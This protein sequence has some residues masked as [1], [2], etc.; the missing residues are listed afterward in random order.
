MKK[1]FERFAQYGIF[2][3]INLTIVGLLAVM[4]ILLVLLLNRFLLLPSLE[5]DK[6]LNE[7][8]AHSLYDVVLS[9]YNTIYNQT[10]LIT[11]TSHV[12][13]TLASAA[14]YPEKALQFDTISQINNYLQ[15]LLY[16]DSD[17]LDTLVLAVETETVY[18][19]SAKKTRVLSTRYD[20]YIR[21][22]EMTHL[23]ESDRNIC[24]FPAS[25]P[26]YATP[27]DT[28]VIT[29]A[30][31][32]YNPMHLPNK[33]LVGV[34]LVS[35]PISVFSNAYQYLGALSDGRVYVLNDADT[36]I[37]SNRSDAIGQPFSQH[38]SSH[39]QTTTYPV[40]ISGIRVLNS[41]SDNTVMKATTNMVR[42][43]LTVVIPSMLAMLLIV[44]LL[45]RQY[46]K[47]IGQLASAMLKIS[48]GGLNTRLPVSQKD[49]IG[50]LSQAF[51][52]MCEK[53]DANIRLAFHAELRR[54]TAEL[55]ALQ[56]QINPHFLYNTIESIRMRAMQDGNLDV[57]DMLMQLGQMFHWMISM[58]Q[59]IVYLEDEIDYNEAYL[60][61]Q[62]LRYEDSFEYQFDIPGDV[63]YFGI[64]KFTLQ[65]IIENAILHGLKENRLSGRITVT[66]LLEGDDLILQVQDN[67]SGIEPERLKRLQRHI[68]GE[69]SDPEF[70]VGMQNVHARIHLLFGGH[71][72]VSIHSHQD[73]GTTVTITLPALAKKEMEQ[74]ISASIHEEHDQEKV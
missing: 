29:F 21:L 19:F 35:Y 36:I 14:V 59:R 4:T 73:A 3:K 47:R 56:A 30:A 1:R 10:N 33:Q 61:L 67:G 39:D 40:G 72:G 51:N 68:S 60:D 32:I 62:K 64:P 26:S 15:T 28:Q 48:L 20:D 71:C 52:R 70:G 17:I 43:M 55:N 16:S 54:K 6:L 37:F 58:D 9:K 63:L 8:S 2:T 45:N 53:L 44:V 25:I 34:F 24:I 13:G 41:I 74:K 46:Q 23:L 12:A 22:P 18:T 50:R 66:A 11:S 31:K 38:T 5:K 57:S 49:E 27:N 69:C 7:E 65:P 42:T